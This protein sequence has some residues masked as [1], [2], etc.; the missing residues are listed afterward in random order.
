MFFFLYYI[1]IENLVQTNYSSK[2]RAY[3]HKCNHLSEGKSLNFYCEIIEIHTIAEGSYMITSDSRSD[4]LAFVY[5]NDDFTLFDLNLNA[6]VSDDNSHNNKQF[7][8]IF[9]RKMNTSFILIVTTNSHREQA[10]FSIT[11]H[12]PNSVSMQRKSRY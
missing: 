8:I 12:G 11:V 2:L 4:I 5:E 6:I 10:A 3:S 1:D 9:Y 7:R